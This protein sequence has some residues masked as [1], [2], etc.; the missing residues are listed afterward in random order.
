MTR[1][2]AILSSFLLATLGGL[3]FGQ[4]TLNVPA[5]YP[6][7]QLAI[8]AAPASAIVAVAPGIY[9]GSINFQGKAITVRGTAGAEQTTLLG[10]GGAR[11]VTF[12]NN[13]GPTSVLEGVTVTGGR[14]GILIQNASPTITNC[15]IVQNLSPTESGGGIRCLA[16]G[17][18]TA[19]PAFMGT[20]VSQNVGMNGGGGIFV[21]TTESASASP[22]FQGCSIVGNIA[23]DA[24]A[25]GTYGGGGIAF[26]ANSPLPGSLVLYNCSVVGNLC[27]GSGGGMRLDNLASVLVLSC[28]MQG[29]RSVAGMANLN[30]STGG[31]FQCSAQ[32]VSIINSLIADNSAESRG[33]GLRIEAPFGQ[34]LSLEILNCTVAGNVAGIHGG[35]LFN[36]SQFQAMATVTSSIFRGNS[37][38]D[39]Y[40]YGNASALVSHSNVGLGLYTPGIGNIT[41]DPQFVEPAAGDYHLAF[42]SPCRDAGFPVPSGLPGQ[43]LDGS[44][45]LQGAVVDMGSDE[46]PAIAF[47]GTGEDLDLYVRVNGAG[48]PLASTIAAPAESLVTVRLDSV[49]GTFSGLWPLILAQVRTTGAPVA[50]NPGFDDIR[51]FLGAPFVFVHGTTAASPFPTPGLPPDGI[52]LAFQ[53]P[54]G[55]SGM[56]V[57]L[58][59]F[60]ATPSSANGLY[61]ASA[62]RD[63]DLP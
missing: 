31:G 1:N 17:T 21:R 53:I 54:P 49:G 48:D 33:G 7:I 14:G 27:S 47:P 52:D 9:P 15:R 45:R 32:Q 29:N 38:L 26:Q 37:G 40:G 30:A 46:V 13:E 2:P 8:N 20:T 56:T 16:T 63:V 43:D 4:P 34:S 11:V 18:G 5:Q 62:A 22:T 39:L 35:L 12:A 36:S 42:S 50:P 59:G 10:S 41:A 58:Q 3:T 28:R 55:L 51:I 23:T 25:V 60:V 24:G 57:R 44:P 61:A 19:S 6:T